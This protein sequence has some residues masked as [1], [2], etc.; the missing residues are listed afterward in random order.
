MS[1]VWG[2]LEGKEGGEGREGKEGEEGRNA[3]RPQ[4]CLCQMVIGDRILNTGLQKSKAN[5]IE[6]T[7]LFH[8]KMYFIL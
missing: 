8:I 2:L 5:K 4:K 6:R 3:C 1:K 7:V